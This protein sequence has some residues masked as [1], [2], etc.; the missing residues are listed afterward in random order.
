MGN[1]P[2][3]KLLCAFCHHVL[4]EQKDII[5]HTYKKPTIDIHGKLSFE[6]TY[7]APDVIKGQARCDSFAKDYTQVEDFYAC[8]GVFTKMMPYMRFDTSSNGGK[9]LCPACSKHVGQ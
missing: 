5:P 8:T 9:I 4:C 1:L 2:N 3:G 7:K 6:E